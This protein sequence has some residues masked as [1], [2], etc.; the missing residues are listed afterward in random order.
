MNTYGMDDQLQS[1]LGELEGRIDFIGAL[2]K[3]AIQH[4]P[5]AGKRELQAKKIA[6]LEE[7]LSA[8]PASANRSTFQHAYAHGLTNEAQTA[9][10]R[11]DT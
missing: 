3:N 4:L 2:L 6:I 8:V 1:A 5:E 7:R 10:I 9:I 11:T